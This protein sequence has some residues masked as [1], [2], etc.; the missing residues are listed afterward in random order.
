MYFSKGEQITLGQVVRRLKEDIPE[1]VDYPE[2]DLRKFLLEWRWAM[3]PI[4]KI[5]PRR[6][7][8]QQGLLS[9]ISTRPGPRKCFVTPSGYEVIKK[10]YLRQLDAER[11]KNG[12]KKPG[13]RTRRGARQFGAI[14]FLK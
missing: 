6:R 10:H 12:N 2:T 13:T 11:S 4:S 8:V 3:G 7:L 9:D 14:A 1:L 5:K